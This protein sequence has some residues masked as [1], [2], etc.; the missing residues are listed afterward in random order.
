MFSGFTLVPGADGKP[1]REYLSDAW[2]Y[3]PK[4][5]WEQLPIY[6]VPP[7]RRQRSK[8]VKR[9]FSSSGHAAKEA[10]FI[11]TLRD[12]WPGFEGINWH[13]TP[14]RARGRHW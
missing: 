13:I 11:D 5:G 7:S 2:R 1:V 10:I 9:K 3:N 12:K 14:L 8:W 4:S 6:R